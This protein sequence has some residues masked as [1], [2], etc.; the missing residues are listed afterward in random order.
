MVGAPIIAGDA[1]ANS[2]GGAAG[3]IGFPCKETSPAVTRAAAVIELVVSCSAMALAPIEF[4]T[5]EQLG[6][7]R[8]V[9]DWTSNPVPLPP[10]ASIQGLSNTLTVATALVATLTS[11]RNIAAS[12][13]GCVCCRVTATPLLTLL[14][15]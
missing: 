9:L 14:S 6:R 4:A 1:K 5:A 7:S 10:S 13:A 11:V 3:S 2:G 8:C 12:K 15:P